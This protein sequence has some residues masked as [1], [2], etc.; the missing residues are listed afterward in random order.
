M[1]E[2]NKEMI[3]IKDQLRKLSNEIQK[4][5]AQLDEHLLEHMIEDRNNEFD[6][7]YPITE[8]E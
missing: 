1:S 8:D 4:V 7:D 2:I 6:L 5:Q 3:R